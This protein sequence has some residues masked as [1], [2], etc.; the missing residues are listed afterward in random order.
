MSTASINTI[1]MSP[2]PPILAGPLEVM[3]RA[4]A[5]KALDKK[6]DKNQPTTGARHTFTV[7]YR[8]TKYR[9]DVRATGYHPSGIWQLDLYGLDVIG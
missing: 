4:G 8:E 3:I 1:Q 5:A 9:V 6:K 2:V 7:K